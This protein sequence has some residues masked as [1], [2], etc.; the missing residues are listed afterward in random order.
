ML[1]QS[2]IILAIVVY[3]CGMLYIGISFSKKKPCFSI[4]LGLYYFIKSL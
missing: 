4:Q 3:L 1:T 2:C